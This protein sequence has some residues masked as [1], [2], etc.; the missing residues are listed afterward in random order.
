M[1]SLADIVGVWS[2]ES[3]VEMDA[4][5]GA[6]VL[7][8]GEHPTGILR[9]TSDGFMSAQLGRSERPHFA[10]DDMVVGTE[11]KCAAAGYS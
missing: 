1:R 11:A 4:E 9:Y 7:T 6:L 3:Y 5:S 10:N 2:L 8:M